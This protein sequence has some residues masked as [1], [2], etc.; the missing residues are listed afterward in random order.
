MIGKNTSMYELMKSYMSE[1]VDTVSKLLDSV[2]I[3]D[4]SRSIKNMIK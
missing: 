1:S 4:I 2:A 3:F